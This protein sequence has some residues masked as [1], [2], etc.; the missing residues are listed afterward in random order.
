MAVASFFCTMMF[1]VTNFDKF[2]RL[3]PHQGSVGYSGPTLELTGLKR[4]AVL[5]PDPTGHLQRY[6]E[7]HFLTFGFVVLMLWLVTRS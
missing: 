6:S 3:Q 2:L 7:V 4:S 5:V 1:P